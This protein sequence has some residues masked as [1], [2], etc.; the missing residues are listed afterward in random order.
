[1]I[2]SSD[3]KDLF[4]KGKF[5]GSF[6]I[7][8]F[9]NSSHHLKLSWYRFTYYLS[10]LR[11][12]LWE[13]KMKIWYE[14]MIAMLLRWVIALSHCT[15]SL[16]SVIALSHCTQSL[17]SVIALSH[18]TQS[19]HSVIALSHCTQSLHS[20]IALSRCTQSLHSASPLSQSTQSVYPASSLSQSTQ[21][22]YSVNSLSV[23]TK[24]FTNLLS[25]VDR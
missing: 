9:I 1:M 6:S 25:E 21:P 12:L 14:D 4:S 17:H 8:Y 15:Q 7:R 10:T 5:F 22:V 23:W 24:G 20:V 3:Q 16:H 19:L 18:C 13:H 11:Y 2:K